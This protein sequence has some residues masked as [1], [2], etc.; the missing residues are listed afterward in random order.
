MRDF[1]RMSDPSA[2]PPTRFTSPFQREEKR[3]CLTFNE[4]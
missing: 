1:S 2:Q 3:V 4:K